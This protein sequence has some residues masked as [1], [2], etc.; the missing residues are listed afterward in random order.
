MD[1]ACVCD[2]WVWFVLV[3][4]YVWRNL[5]DE[6]EDDEER[7]GIILVLVILWARDIEGDGD[8]RKR[9]SLSILFGKEKEIGGEFFR[10]S[11]RRRNSEK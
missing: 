2:L 9:K 11:I 6:E 5:W 7:D 3:L 8:E 1:S 4:Y 10:K